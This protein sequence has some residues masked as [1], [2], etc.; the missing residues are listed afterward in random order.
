MSLFIYSKHYAILNEH[1]VDGYSNKKKR[2]K[3]AAK[4][5]IYL[6]SRAVNKVSNLITTSPPNF[7]LQS[8]V[9]IG[10][11]TCTC[12]SSVQLLSCVRLFA[13]P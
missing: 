8:L 4:T 1:S 13:T 2:K 10:Y 12:F 3:Q 11:I 5:G 7:H 6:I 9:F